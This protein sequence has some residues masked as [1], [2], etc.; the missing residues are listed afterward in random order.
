MGGGWVGLFGGVY[1]RKGVKHLISYQL[2]PYTRAKSEPIGD[3]FYP[4]KK[5]WSIQNKKKK[6]NKNHLKFFTSCTICMSY[7]INLL[8]GYR[9]TIKCICKNKFPF[10]KTNENKTKHSTNL[11]H[12]KIRVRT[13]ITTIT[14]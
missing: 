3:S 5:H 1:L 14:F 9:L 13:Y 2:N 4:T 6:Q 8:Y 7:P 11:F 12:S 10:L